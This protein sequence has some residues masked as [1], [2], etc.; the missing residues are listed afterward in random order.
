V[1]Q[2]WQ[3]AAV[4]IQLHG[5]ERSARRQRYDID[6]RGGGEVKLAERRLQHGAFRAPRH[7]AGGLLR[8]DARR[9]GIQHGTQLVGIVGLD[10]LNNAGA[11]TQRANDTIRGF[12]RA[13]E[14]G[15]VVARLGPREQR[16]AAAAIG[17]DGSDEFRAELRHLVDAQRQHICRQA[18]A[19]PRQRIDDVFAVLAI[20]KQH[21][22]VA[23][24]GLAVGLQQRAQPPHQGVGARQ[25]IGGR[26]GRTYRS[27]GAAAGADIGVDRDGIAVWR[28]RAGR[29]QVEAARAAGNGRARMRAQR[30][31]EIDKARLVEGADQHAGIRNRALDGGLVARIGA[32]ITGAQFM[33]GKQRCAAGEI[34]DQ[35]AGG[36]GAVTRGAEHE[37]CARGGRGQRVVV[38]RKFERPEMSACIADRALEH[39]KFVGAA[40]RHVAGPGEEYGDV[41]TIGETL[42]RLD[43]NLVAAI[44]QRN[45]AALKRDQRDRRHLFARRGNQRCRFRTG[46][47]RIL[48]PAAGLTDVDEGKLSLRRILRDFPKQCFF[49]GAGDRDRQAFDERLLEAVEVEAA[50]LVRLADPGRAAT[51]DRFRIERHGLLATAN[52]EAR[53]RRTHF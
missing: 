17:E 14:R 20:V 42:R 23:S 5:A 18:L 22:S 47:G 38:D 32:Q 50:E 6:R 8:G 49:L 37:F 2:A 1:T 48:R 10:D 27:A 45:A 40:R 28:D 52:Q 24:A 33:R 26:A 29:T 16:G 4:D 36:S 51:T 34:Q 21:R 3:R 19:E 35:I 31:L 41:Q 39:G 12:D 43:G 53:R 46:C 13:A 9:R 44:D 7:E 11:E 30:R 25:R 15:D